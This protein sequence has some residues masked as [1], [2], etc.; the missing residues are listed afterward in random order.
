[1][2]KT[3]KQEEYVR[4]IIVGGNAGGA[5][6]AARLRRLDEKAELVV[7]EKGDYIS[8]ANCGLPYHIGNVIT[9]RSQLLV[10]TPA[11]M[12]E[13]FNIDF[14]TGR[15]VTSID[16]QEHTVTVKELATGIETID[17]YDKLVLS[18]GGSPL[19]PPIPGIDSEGIYSL[20]TIPDMDRIIQAVH[21]GARKAVVVGGGFIG[22]EVAENLREQKVDVALVEMLPQV[23]AFL[24]PDIA[25]Y[26]HQEL[27]IHGVDLH[28]GD[29]VKSF[30]KNVDGTLTVTLTSGTQLAADMVILAIGVR[31]NTQIAE[32]AGL[33]IGTSHGVLVDEHLRTSDPDIY[34]IGD[35]IEVE[36][37]ITKSK[38][39][40]PLAGPANRQARIAANNIVGRDDIYKG[41]Q[42]TSIVKVFDLAAGATGASAALLT[43]LGIPFRSIT[44]HPGSHAGYYPGSTPVHIKL[45]YSPE[46]KLLGAQAAGYDGVDKRIDVLATAMRLGATV[47]DLTDLELAYAPPYGSAKDPVNMAGFVAQNDL[48]NLAP[49]V[50]PDHLAEE[51]AKGAI[52]LDVRE[53]EETSCGIIPGA[54]TIPLPE[55][56]NRIGELPVGKKIILTYCKAGLRGYVAQRILAQN[57]F[58]VANLTG[59]YTSWEA[60]VTHGVEEQPT[61]PEREADDQQTCTSGP[62]VTKAELPVSR[63]PASAKTV[64]I[65]ACGLQCPGPLL[66]LKEALATTGP[67]DMI[68]VTASD[69]GFYADVAA[70][71]QAQGLEVVDRQRGKLITATLRKPAQAAA[72][73]GVAVGPGK[74]DDHATI[75]VFS[76]DLDKVIAAFIIANGAQA[77]GK[78][79]SMFFTF[80]GLNVLRKDEN[81]R[82]KKTFIERMFG[83]MMPRGATHLIL[84]K[85]H[86][87]GMGTSMILGLMKKYNVTPV[88]AM[89]RSVLDGG[90]KFIA[91][92]MSMN[93]MGIH[94]EELIDGIEEGG[95]A[96]ML[97]DADQGH[98][99]FFI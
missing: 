82:I 22:V 91:C 11:S 55:L 30:A 99:N 33:T 7:Y 39:L 75:I 26:A 59:G 35:V 44:I 66:K 32:H 5:S 56:R 54:L 41:T 83:M 85:M 40:I 87:M 90:G 80:W 72:T 18:P 29:G 16:R 70:F 28:L 69:P 20:W 25:A 62:C 9:D 49:V 51:L 73:P 36:H 74:A 10:Q 34:A 1:M 46:G 6:A 43:K 95:V 98:I 78:K 93:L 47:D 27:Q 94:R 17:R 37:F 68:K 38:A 76:N 58:Q 14:L 24:D 67:G 71:A 92:T 53:P 96:T 12:K 86:M 77:M 84:G 61:R 63:T 79:I 57:G 13:R 45:L 81:V 15:E 65:D 8:F 31:P 97:G 19:R 88:E 89:M 50:A 3:R 2:K 4:V 21:A 23:L 60:S 64:E 42:G 48:E 52:L